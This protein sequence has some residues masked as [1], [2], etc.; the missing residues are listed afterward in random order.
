MDCVKITSWCDKRIL[1]SI[2][3]LNGVTNKKKNLLFNQSKKERNLQMLFSSRLGI[4]IWMTSLPTISSK[5][6]LKT[7]SAREYF[8]HKCD[9]FYSFVWVHNNKKK[10]T[11]HTCGAR[12]TVCTTLVIIKGGLW[13][14]W[15]VTC[16]PAV[17][18]W[19]HAPLCSACAYIMKLLLKFFIKCS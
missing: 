13:L 6:L 12:Q 3:F 9:S 14:D 18:K 17:A 19:G 15:H 5:L 4:R 7:L 16:S 1:N 2:I 11:A 8:L 10:N